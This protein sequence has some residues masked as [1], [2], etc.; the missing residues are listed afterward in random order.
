MSTIGGKDLISKSIDTVSWSWTDD[1]GQLHTQKLNNGL[2]STESPVN[3]IS[4]TALA[5]ST[6][7]HEVTWVPIKIEYYIFKWYFGKYKNTIFYPENCLL[8][9]ET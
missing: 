7:G 3:I 2:Y 9:L 5:E 4:A 8:E 6:K 1:E